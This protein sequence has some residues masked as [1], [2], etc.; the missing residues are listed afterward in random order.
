MI[1]SAYFVLDKVYELVFV[2]VHF[3]KL[4]PKRS[5]ILQLQTTLFIPVLVL[6]VEKSYLKFVFHLFLITQVFISFF[7]AA[8]NTQWNYWHVAIYM[9]LFAIR[10]FLWLMGCFL[11]EMFEWLFL[12]FFWKSCFGWSF[13]AGDSQGF[14]GHFLFPENFVDRV[15]FRWSAVPH[16]YC[17]YWFVPNQRIWDWLLHLFKLRKLILDSLR[18]VIWQSI[19]IAFKFE[20]GEILLMVWEFL[21][22]LL[23]G[24]IVQEI[25]LGL[26]FEWEWIMFGFWRVWVSDFHR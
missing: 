1:R 26:F 8:Q 12:Q 7:F 21:F 3:P 6:F 5:F 2:P 18:M 19:V 25:K 15:L 22:D 17:V 24:L 16:T 20:D 13:G 23:K 11:P 14:K 9:I 4:I 10:C